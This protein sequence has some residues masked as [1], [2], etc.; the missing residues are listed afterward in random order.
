MA[1]KPNK[2]DRAEV[3]RHGGHAQSFSLPRGSRCT[4]SAVNYALGLYT[5]EWEATEV[6]FYYRGR[7]CGA[8]ILDNDTGYFTRAM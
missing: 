1:I 5:G 8:F 3:T 7:P 4:G 2:A 6:Q